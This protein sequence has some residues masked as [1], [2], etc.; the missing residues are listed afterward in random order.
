MEIVLDHRLFYVLI[1]VLVVATVAGLAILGR[2]YTPDPPR[3]IGWVDW[4]TRKTEEKYREELAELRQD[5][6]ELT[7]ILQDQQPDPVQAEMAASRIAQRHI[8]GLGLLARQREAV[9]VAAEVVRDWAAGYVAY[10]DAVATV[11]E[12]TSIVGTAEPPAED[13]GTLLDEETE[14][15]WSD[16]DA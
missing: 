11:N 3:V 7:Q 15:W 6:S 9:V 16:D 8:D 4:T 5:L 14:E 12:A 1:T 13:S 10:E 2:P